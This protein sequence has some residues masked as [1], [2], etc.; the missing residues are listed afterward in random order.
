MVVE[1]GPSSCSHVPGGG[2][3]SDR[4]LGVYSFRASV[5]LSAPDWPSRWIA[6]DTRQRGCLCAHVQGWLGLEVADVV[7][8]MRHFLVPDNDLSV[9]H[10]ISGYRVCVWSVRACVCFACA[11]DTTVSDL[12]TQIGTWFAALSGCRSSVLLFCGALSICGV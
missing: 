10:S 9:A 1:E 7:S 3:H 6:G 5:H 8:P 4:G 11:C 2:R 12:L